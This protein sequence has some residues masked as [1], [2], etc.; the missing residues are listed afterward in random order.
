MAVCHLPG[1]CEAACTSVSKLC[2]H[3]VIL[4][5]LP[6]PEGCLPQPAW[7]GASSVLK[8]FRG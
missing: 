7:Q 3:L 2:L 4:C 5:M 6:L 8:R 1:G